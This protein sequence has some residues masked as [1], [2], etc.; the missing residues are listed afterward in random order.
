M[1]QRAWVMPRY[2]LFYHFVWT[3][4]ERFPLITEANREP[5][6]AAIGAKVIELGGIVHAVNSM[7]DHIHLVASV[8]P[9]IALS[10]IVGQMKGVSSHLAAH[11]PDHDAPF[12]WQHDYGVVSLSESHLPVVV[13]YVEQQHH[14]N[15][16]TL[17]ARLESVE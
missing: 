5:I 6:F 9:A 3:T 13:R 2:R 14:Q 7:P 16:Q 12:A 4:K 1:R 8:P 17:D 10:E 11:L 15:T